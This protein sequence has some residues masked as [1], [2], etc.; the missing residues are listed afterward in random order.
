[1]PAVQVT[2]AGLSIRRAGAIGRCDGKNMDGPGGHFKGCY[3]KQR[4]VC[5]THVFISC[6]VKQFK[7]TC[8][9]LTGK[10]VTRV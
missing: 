3:F 2:G 8:E 9:P 4:A 7:L 1:M 5:S 6:R 10:L